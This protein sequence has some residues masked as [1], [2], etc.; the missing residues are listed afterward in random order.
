M[1][2]DWRTKSFAYHIAIT[3]YG[4]WWVH[5]LQSAYHVVRSA[6]ANPIKALRVPDST[7]SPMESLLGENPSYLIEDHCDGPHYR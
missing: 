3:R 7:N 5:F 4:S 6:R 2:F 1:R